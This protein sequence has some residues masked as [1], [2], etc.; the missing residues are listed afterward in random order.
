MHITESELLSLAVQARQNAYCPYSH[1]A[2]GAAL[3]CKDGTVYTGCNVENG[4][5]S[6]GVCA[7][8]TAIFKAV[9]EGKKNGDFEMIAIAGAPEGEVPEKVCPPCGACRQVMTEF[10]DDSFRIILADGTHT[11]GEL[12]PMRFGLE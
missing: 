11:L 7:E 12:F 6:L 9:S 8:R 4:S 2:V 5:Y 3:L 1:F 10:C